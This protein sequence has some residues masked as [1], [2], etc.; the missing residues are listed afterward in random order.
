MASGLAR[1]RSARSCRHVVRR[2]RQRR[3]RQSPVAMGRRDLRYARA[4]SDACRRLGVRT[5]RPR[6]QAH[7]RAPT[8]Q[9]AARCRHCARHDRWGPGCAWRGLAGVDAPR[10]NDLGLL[11]LR[12]PIQSRP[13]VS[14]LGLAPALASGA[15]GAERHLSR[16]AGCGL[17]R[18]P[19]VRAESAGRPSR[20]P[21]AQHRARPARSG[22]PLFGRRA[23]EHGDPF[24]LPG[25]N[26][27]ARHAVHRLRRERGRACDPDR[28]Q[29]GSLAPRLSAYPLGDLG[30]P[31]RPSGLS[32]CPALS[33]NLAV[34]RHAWKRSGGGGSEPAPFS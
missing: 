28:A 19:H 10:R 27:G 7:R 2:D 33:A 13:G 34:R 8:N 26:L 32:A 31:D 21:V 25:R 22:D 1:R 29:A 3:V 18:A 15:S 5:S 12:D 6:S 16:D 9:S 17:Y 20:R 4:R 23:L 24:R 14:V 30:L 11:R